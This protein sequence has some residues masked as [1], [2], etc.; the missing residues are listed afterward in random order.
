MYFCSNSKRIPI[1][2]VTDVE[3]LSVYFEKNLNIDDQSREASV[4]PMV[5]NEDVVEGD[6]VNVIYPNEEEER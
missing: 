1:E 5:N 6:F 3:E 4:S 2:T